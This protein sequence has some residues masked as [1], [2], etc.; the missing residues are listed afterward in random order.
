MYLAHLNALMWSRIFQNPK[1]SCGRVKYFKLVLLLKNNFA[2][3]IYH[4][5]KSGAFLMKYVV[6]MNFYSANTACH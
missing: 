5:R 4:M 1:Y 2:G 3:D 6:E